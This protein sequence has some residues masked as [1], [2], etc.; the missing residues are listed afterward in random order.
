[1]R[2][3]IVDGINFKRPMEIRKLVLRITNSGFVSLSIADE[4]AGQ[5]LQLKIPKEAIDYMNG[6]EGDS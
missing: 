3:W 1:M 6:K 2:S 5:M 4:K